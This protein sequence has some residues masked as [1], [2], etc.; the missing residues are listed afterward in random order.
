MSTSMEAKSLN[1]I[2]V[3]LAPQTTYLSTVLFSPCPLYMALNILFSKNTFKC[4][5]GAFYVPSIDH[6]YVNSLNPINNPEKG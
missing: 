6:I 4:V 5:L 3:Y 1:S 2:Q